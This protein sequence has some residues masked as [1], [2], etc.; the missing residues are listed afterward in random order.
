M[1]LRFQFFFFIDMNTWQEDT[2]M[3]WVNCVRVLIVDFSTF[4]PPSR[5]ILCDFENESVKNKGVYSYSTT[6]WNSCQTVKSKQ[7]VGTSRV[8][9]QLCLTWVFQTER[10]TKHSSYFHLA[11]LPVV[12]SSK[13][14]TLR[15]KLY[16]EKLA[17]EVKIAEEKCEEEIRLLRVEAERRAELLELKRRT[18]EA[19]LEVAYEDTLAIED[20]NHGDIDD[21]DLAGLPVDSVED[22]FLTLTSE[23]CLQHSDCCWW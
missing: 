20:S 10:E 5:N 9:V 19:K 2:N 17:L 22:R 21:K 16:T 13:S 23:L 1:C 7:R 15:N 14:S 18:K 3:C 8:I 11:N 12:Q 4:V 6:E